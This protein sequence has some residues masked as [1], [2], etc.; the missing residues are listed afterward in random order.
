MPP[1][2]PSDRRVHRSRTAL[3]TALLDLIREHD[4]ARITILDITRRAGVNRSTFYEHYGS[5]GDLAAHACAA[6]FDE[7]IAAAPVIGGRY[8]IEEPGP[9]ADALTDV[10]A[11]VA[12]HARLYGALLGDGGSAHVIDHMHQRLTASVR[13]NLVRGGGTAAAS[14]DTAAVVLAGALVG[15]VLDRLRRGCPGTAR[16]MSAA[17]IPLLHGAALAAGAPPPPPG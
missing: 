2:E 4:L 17:V 7:L 8:G 15:A 5:V 16:Q 6:M 10:F 1:R 11:H 3:E 12:E 13:T 9:A 14:P